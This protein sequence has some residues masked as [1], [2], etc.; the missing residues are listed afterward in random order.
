M[1]LTL[2]LLLA[3]SVPLGE[4]VAQERAWL[5]EADQV[6]GIHKEKG[7]DEWKSVIFGP[8]TKYIITLSENGAISFRRFGAESTLKCSSQNIARNTLSCSNVDSFSSIES[9]VFDSEKLIFSAS[10][11]HSSTMALDLGMPFYVA[12]GRCSKI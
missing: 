3:I 8:G 9:I 6:A 4:A 5:C 2:V 7:D 12:K 1:R 11:I 10:F